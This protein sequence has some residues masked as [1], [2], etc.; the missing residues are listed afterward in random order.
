MTK[1]QCP[2]DTRSQMGTWRLCVP[3]GKPWLLGV[4]REPQPCLGM[5]KRDRA[6]SCWGRS[7]RTWAQ[8]LQGGGEGKM[9]T[10]DSV[11]PQRWTGTRDGRRALW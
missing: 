10:A 2:Q 5:E 8:G 7:A 1:A 4:W 3:A 11:S 6:Q 9:H